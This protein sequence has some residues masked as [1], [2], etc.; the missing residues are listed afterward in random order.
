MSEIVEIVNHPEKVIPARTERKVVGHR[1]D[2]CG[3]H[4]DGSVNTV[5]DA[6]VSCQRGTNFGSDGGDIETLE[7]DICPEC[8]DFYIVG[9]FRERGIH[10]RAS[11]K[12]W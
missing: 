6:L 9:L 1:C 7:F 4:L 11:R 8:F 2:S 10:P 5:S 3:K 12:Q